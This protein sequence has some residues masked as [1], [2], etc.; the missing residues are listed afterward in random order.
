MAG[1]FLRPAPRPAAAGV[2]EHV[3]RTLA[4]AGPVIVARCGMLV[5]FT[6]DT[7]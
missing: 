5:M 2:A 3:R 7:S 6:V 4:L 1:R